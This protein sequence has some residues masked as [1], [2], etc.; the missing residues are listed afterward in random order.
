L[1]PETPN[2]ELH[3]ISSESI[4]ASLPE[5]LR[6]RLEALRSRGWAIDWESGM[7]VACHL[8]LFSSSRVQGTGPDAEAAARDAI[9][10]VP[11]A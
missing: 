5:D 2:G 1:S 6:D 8:I 11:G 3:H 10:Q 9:A 7:P 4:L